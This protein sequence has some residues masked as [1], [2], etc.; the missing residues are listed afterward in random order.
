KVGFI[1]L[2]PSRQQVAREREKAASA[3][4]PPPPRPS[5]PQRSGPPQRGDFRQQFQRGR[6]GR[7]SF[8]SQ[9]EPAKPAAPVQPK[10]VAPAGGEVIIIKPPIV[11]REL[12]AQL[13]QKP[14]KVIADL[15]GL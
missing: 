3:K 6:D 13:K 7:P 15:M 9:R 12:A 14:F 10:F 11:V 5:A 8:Q 2:P 1:Q 4:L